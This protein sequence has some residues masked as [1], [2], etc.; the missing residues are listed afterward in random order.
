M[1]LSSTSGHKTLECS[2]EGREVASV[3]NTENPVGKS[4]AQSGE[5]RS[6]GTAGEARETVSHSEVH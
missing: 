4:K 2:E 1:S 6:G 3:A 5:R